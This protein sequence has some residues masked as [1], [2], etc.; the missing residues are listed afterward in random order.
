M[1]SVVEATV[2]SRGSDGPPT[3]PAGHRPVVAPAPAGRGRI[4]LLLLAIPLAL[5]GVVLGIGLILAGTRRTTSPVTQVALTLRDDAIAVT[6]G[7]TAGL[8]DLTVTNAGTR[9]HGFLIVA[10]DLAPDALPLTPDGV[11][12]EE[13]D[14]VKGAFES[15]EPTDAGATTTMRAGLIPGHYVLVGHEPGDYAAGMHAPFTVFA[16]STPATIL[17]AVVADFRLT[18]TYPTVRAGLID[19]P[20]TND[21]PSPHELI[22]FATDLAPDAMPRNAEGRIDE[23]APSVKNDFDTGDNVAPGATKRFQAVLQ[24]GHYV[25]VCN[26]PAHYDKGMRTALTVTA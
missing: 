5:A 15:E 12:D 3:A 21:G 23:E 16:S 19:I 20:I 4:A 18:L 10:T 13:A 24:P 11:V 14:G 25:V 26:L 17:P 7:T 8:V 6:S 1:G 2:A 22:V 9:P